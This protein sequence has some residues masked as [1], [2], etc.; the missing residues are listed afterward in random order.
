MIETKRTEL[1][2]KIV[3]LI[4]EYQSECGFN[5]HEKDEKLSELKWLCTINAIPDM[6]DLDYKISFLKEK[7][8]RKK[9]D[10]KK[11][12]IPKERL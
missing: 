7:K 1:F 4:E 6:I 12:R 5:I 11:P 8:N 3:R 2:E 9:I 10:R